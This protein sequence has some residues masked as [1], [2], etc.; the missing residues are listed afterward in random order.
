MFVLCGRRCGDGSTEVSF[1]GLTVVDAFGL[2]GQGT[3]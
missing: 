2:T 1:E 3:A